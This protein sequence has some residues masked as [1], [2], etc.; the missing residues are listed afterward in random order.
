MKINDF[1]VFFSIVLSM[2]DK[3]KEKDGGIVNGRTL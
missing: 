2:F 1:F 3:I